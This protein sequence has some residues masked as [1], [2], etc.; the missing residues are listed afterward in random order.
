ML[1]E[2]ADNLRHSKSKAPS[3][4][5]CLQALTKTVGI[6]ANVHADRSFVGA[7]SRARKNKAGEAGLSDRDKPGGSPTLEVILAS[8]LSIRTHV[9][10]LCAKCR[11]LADAF[12]R[13]AGIRLLLFPSLRVEKHVWRHRVV[14]HGKTSFGL[15]EDHQSG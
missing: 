9:S 5:L 4:G 11:Q 10:S 7:C 8:P 2:N 14:G 15:G 12:P 6:C 1:R 13:D 3:Q